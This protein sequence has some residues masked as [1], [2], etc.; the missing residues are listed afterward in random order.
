MF[1]SAIASDVTFCVVSTGDA[2]VN[3]HALL[4]VMHTIW[5]REHNRVARLLRKLNTH[6]D[7][8]RLFQESRRI[9]VAQY[10]HIVYK[11]WMPLIIGTSYMNSFELWPL[12]KGYS[13]SYMD[14]FDPRIT[15][16]FAGAGFR[17]GHS[18][19]PETLRRTPGRRGVRQGRTTSVGLA[20][21]FFNTGLLRNSSGAFDDLVR[22]MADQEGMPWDNSFVPAI[23]DHLFDTRKVG[24]LD[25]VALNIQRG[26]DHGLP[27]MQFK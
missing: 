11:E 6:W 7:D 5:M 16:E 22:G 27:G 15:N 20:E 13:N 17:F 3:E 1:E 25:L 14:S 8:E 12:S 23:Q 19:V 18:L 10:Q 4:V 2:R 24:G 21:N 26:R 9:V